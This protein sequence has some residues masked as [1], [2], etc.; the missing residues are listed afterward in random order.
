MADNGKHARFTDDTVEGSH[1]YSS[2]T[3][4]NK[5]GSMY[6]TDPTGPH[7]IVSKGYQYGFTPYKGTPDP[8]L[9]VSK[10]FENE[11]SGGRRRKTTKR[12]KS[13]IRKHNRKGSR[14]YR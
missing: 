10:V 9:D 7:P 5:R 11:N 2:H 6:L 4:T 12:R 1:G 3:N 14:R 13:K 8:N